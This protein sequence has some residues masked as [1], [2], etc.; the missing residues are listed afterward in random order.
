MKILSDKFGGRGTV[1]LDKIGQGELPTVLR[2]SF[3]SSFPFNEELYK[4]YALYT[5]KRQIN[6]T[7]I[8]LAIS[9][10]MS[11]VNHANPNLANRLILLARS[12]RSTDSDESGA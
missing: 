12:Q 3:P 6:T 11:V 9:I 10:V 5:V 8:S 2:L 1:A 4:M 7:Q